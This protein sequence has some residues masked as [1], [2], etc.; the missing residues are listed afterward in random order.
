M[1][2]C[3]A[4][5]SDDGLNGG[6]GDDV[7]Y[8]GRSDD[9]L[10]GGP[11]VDSFEG[12]PGNDV[13]MVDYFDF[14]DGKEPPMD[15]DRMMA[16][17]AFDGGENDD[18]TADGDTLSFADFMDEDGD[19]VG[20][21]VDMTNARVT[22]KGSTTVSNFFKNIENLIGSRYGDDLTG[23][24]G[25]NV[26]EGGLG[27]DDLDGG[28][29]DTVSY[30]NSPSSVT[31][32][33]N[34]DA[35]KGDAAGDMLSG[36][37][38]IIGSAYDDILTGN[39]SN[40]TIEG[41]GGADTLDGGPGA[42]TFSGDSQDSLSY[43][44]SSSGVRVDLSEGS[45]TDGVI[46]IKTVS[47]GDASGDKVTYDQFLNII[48]SR[49]S[50]TLTGD[51][52]S[53]NIDINIL[54]GRGGNDTLTG[55]GGDDILKGGEDRDTL[56]G[57]EGDDTLDGGG[58]ELAPG[59]DTATYA[60]ATEGVT[61]DLSGGNRGQGDA[62]GDTFTGIEQY[63]GSA[64]DDTFIAGKDEHDIN[65]GEGSDTVSYE[66]S[67]K[68]VQVN[69]ASTAE[70]TAT[71]NYD[72][73]D[74][75]AKGDELD[76]IEN[77]I[78]SSYADQL[79]AHGNGSVINGGRGD[80]RLTGNNGSDTFKFASGD[81]DD[82]VF[83]FETDADKID[84]SA[85]SSIASMEDLDINPVGAINENTEIDLPGN[86]EI[87]LYSV[88]EGD[89]TPDNFIFHD[90]PVNGTNSS[91]VL[92]GDLYNN[93]MDG[94]G[95]DDRMYGEAGRDVLKGGSGDD[96]MYGGEDN[97]L[98]DGGPGADTFVFEPG[99]GNDCIMDFTSSED[100]IDLSAFD[101]ITSENISAIITDDGD[102]AVINL[103]NFGGGTITL[104]GVNENDVDT[105]DDF[106]FIS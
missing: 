33:I 71:G 84:L 82:E 57:G 102:N 103:S 25:N 15:S 7:L 61:V 21:T 1:T 106:T 14:T 40:N 2:V 46:Y 44:G 59:S 16:Q 5:D 37:E 53:N 72:N 28:G 3:T 66:R 81:G 36:F 104:L 94:Q 42:D 97:D 9:T 79:T 35:F 29:T 67:V 105:T 63:M 8:G 52:A 90:R 92:E 83:S 56:K 91:N 64:H 22:Y 69:L 13:I 78:G 87:T 96:E 20:V 30:R 62:A 98:M 75:Y 31:V 32:T 24:A 76:N 65:G 39:D 18:G 58:T 85:Y 6:G 4:N 70:Q 89:L 88:E 17:G 86:G 99:N 49:G 43:E 23:D 19:G 10:K 73:E 27:I 95:G 12:G 41:L 50:D 51:D 34:G 68:G 74:N 48:G 54:E 60:S 77:V 38:N 26:I 45:E 55:N 80:D 101:G 47:G 11:G 100:T 93:T